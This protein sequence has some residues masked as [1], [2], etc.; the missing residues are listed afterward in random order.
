MEF[1]GVTNETARN[2]TDVIRGILASNFSPADKEAQI[3]RVILIVG[4]DYHM[5]MY[6]AASQ[7]F[8]SAA[9][10]SAGIDRANGQAERLANKI[11]RN[12][13]LS[14]GTVATLITEFYN[15][16]LGR[17]QHEAFQNA[18]SMQKHPTLTRELGPKKDCDWCIRK[19]GTHPNP[20]PEDFGRHDNCDCIFIVSGYNTRNGLLN[21]YVKV[22]K[23]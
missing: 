6:R 19:R 2:V 8:D 3:A 15:T 16:L 9:I 11:V 20:K 12:Y 18:L 10:T 23:R 4:N 21:N 1:S 17:A 22:R 7:V 13:A 14:R 5:Q